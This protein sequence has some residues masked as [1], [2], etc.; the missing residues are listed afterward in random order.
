MPEIIGIILIV[1]VGGLIGFLGDAVFPGEILFS[2]LGAILACIVGA[3]IGTLFFPIGPQLFGLHVVSA[4]LGA[5]ILGT[6]Y[7]LI[8]TIA[9][10][11]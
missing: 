11:R 1:V 4:L 3:F 7:E 9:V 8:L 5:I 10:G 6:V 2:W